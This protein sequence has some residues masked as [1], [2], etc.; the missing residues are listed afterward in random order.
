MAHHQHNH[1]FFFLSFFSLLKQ[2]S[3][4]FSLKLNFFLCFLQ[5]FVRTFPI[6]FFSLVCKN[7]KKN[8]KKKLKQSFFFLFGHT[9]IQMLLYFISTNLIEVYIGTDTYT[10]LIY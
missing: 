7:Q 1:R 2:I 8:Q 5:I 6:I 3:I 9:E 10:A 4:I